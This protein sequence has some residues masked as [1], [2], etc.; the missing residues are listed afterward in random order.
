MKKL[1]LYLS[2]GTIHFGKVGIYR[3]GS[4]EENYTSEGLNEFIY[5][6][7]NC[8]FIKLYSSEKKDIYPYHSIVKVSEVTEEEYKQILRDKKL[9][10]IIR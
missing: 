3:V 10:K 8:A 1:L 4:I 2:D 6:S 5:F 9:E 7:K